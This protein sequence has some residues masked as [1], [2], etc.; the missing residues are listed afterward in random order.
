M[1]HVEVSRSESGNRVGGNTPCAKNTG[2]PPSTSRC[3][4]AKARSFDTLSTG[5]G[6][7]AYARERPLSPYALP[8]RHRS[9]RRLSVYMDSNDAAPEGRANIHQRHP[10]TAPAKPESDNANYVHEGE[11]LSLPPRFSCEPSPGYVGICAIGNTS[12]RRRLEEDM[13]IDAPQIPNSG[14]SAH[15]SDCDPGNVTRSAFFAR[16][17]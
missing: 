3:L 8:E 15:G 17:G 9:A 13:E 1:A 4:A 12:A 2:D 11:T 7:T 6:I 10:S 16:G 5:R 14:R